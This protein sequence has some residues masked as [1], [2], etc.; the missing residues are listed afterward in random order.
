MAATNA[1][2]EAQIVRSWKFSSSDLNECSLSLTMSQRQV[3]GESRLVTARSASLYSR[4]FTTSFATRR[5]DEAADR[6]KYLR[7]AGV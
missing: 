1:C 7:Q 6:L 5:M 2:D 3:I 4:R